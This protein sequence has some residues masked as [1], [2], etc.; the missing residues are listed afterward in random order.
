MDTGGEILMLS[1]DYAEGGSMSGYEA[2]IEVIRRV[3]AA[4]AQLG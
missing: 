2:A 1:V 3:G 4:A